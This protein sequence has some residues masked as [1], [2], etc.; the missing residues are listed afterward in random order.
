MKKLYNGVLQSQTSIDE[1]FIITHANNKKV[2]SVE[3]LQKELK[4]YKGGVILGGIYEN[5]P[6]E[7]YYAFGLN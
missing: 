3:D 4:D 7:V 5:Y 1:G 6:G 2:T